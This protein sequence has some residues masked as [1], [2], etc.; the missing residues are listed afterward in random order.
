MWKFGN[1]ESH[2]QIPK[3]SDFQIIQ[4]RIGMMT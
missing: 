2:F 1:L 3:F 4:I